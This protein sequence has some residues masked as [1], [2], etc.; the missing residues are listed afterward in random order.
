MTLMVVLP[1]LRHGFSVHPISV[2]Q[3]TKFH[4]PYGTPVGWIINVAALPIPRHPS[5]IFGR[6]CVHR[7][8]H[9][10]VWPERRVAIKLVSVK[11]GGHTVWCVRPVHP[12][13]YPPRFS[14]SDSKVNSFKSFKENQVLVS[15][16]IIS[17]SHVIGMCNRTSA[18]SCRGSL[19]PNRG[20]TDGVRRPPFCD[21]PSKG[22]GAPHQRPRV[23]KAKWTSHQF[24]NIVGR[25]AHSN[26][27]LGV[28]VRVRVRV[29]VIVGRTAHSNCWSRRKSFRLAL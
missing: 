20:D 25:T 8:L 21:P 5:C 27:W 2:L 29:R 10:I 28:R 17:M 6:P 16:P 3:L 13:R 26:C 19:L 23:T 24:I 9:W 1:T 7:R 14:R 11:A 22:V 4:L 15:V 18:L 12:K